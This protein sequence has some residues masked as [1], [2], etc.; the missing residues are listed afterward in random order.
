MSGYR[1]SLP[2]WFGRVMHELARF[3]WSSFDPLTGFRAAA[4][5]IAPMLIGASTGFLVQGLFATI[6]ANFLVNTEGKGPTAARL[7]VLAAACFMEPAAL[8][9]GT[10]TATAGLLAIPTVGL[11]VF[12]LLTGRANQT[13]SQVALISAVTFSAGVGIP[14]ASI[15]SAS[16]RFWA[17]MLGDIWILLGLTIQR[18]ARRENKP[19][20]GPSQ[21]AQQQGQGHVHPFLANIS[22]HSEAFRQALVTGVAA[23]AGLAVGL[24]L[25]LPR[26][27]WI[28][29]TIIIAIRPGVG[30]TIN[31]TIVLITGTGIGAVLAGGITAGSSNLDLLATLLFCFAFVMY[32]SRLV[33]QAL[34][35]ASLTPFLIILLNILY[36]GD[37]WFSVVRIIDVTIGGLIAIGAVYLLSIEQR[38]SRVPA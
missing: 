21:V 31:S 27:I 12:L 26:D 25:N 15:S 36:P 1:E 32:A 22:V 16:E 17:A 4:F 8:A 3:E 37:W 11:V 18:V 24:A 10:L 33:S 6:A 20:V 29:V 28:L 14:G 13:W 23:S 35:Q 30:P 2:Q 9:T 5:V 19:S 38:G 34:Y 7:T